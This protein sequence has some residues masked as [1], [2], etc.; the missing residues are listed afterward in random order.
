M[1]E[2][3]KSAQDQAEQTKREMEEGE[4]ARKLMEDD[5]CTLHCTVRIACDDQMMVW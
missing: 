4:R 2:T 3:L 1:V 5:V